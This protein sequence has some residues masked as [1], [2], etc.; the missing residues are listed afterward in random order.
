MDANRDFEELF[1]SL[2]AHRI[3]Y[4]VVGAYAVMHYSVPRFTRDIDI[5]IP[6]ELND[7][8]KTHRALTAFGAPMKDVRPEDLTDKNNILQIGVEPIRIDILT[9]IEGLS[10]ERAWRTRAQG[11]YGKARIAILGLSELIMTKRAAG[12]PQD[13]LDLAMLA[14]RPPARRPG[15]KY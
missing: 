15:R 2:N 8:R 5:W 10:P 6:P 12:R 3:K 13:K 14:K 9:S 11:R 4:L 1:R 7:P